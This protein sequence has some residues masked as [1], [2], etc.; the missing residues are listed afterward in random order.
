MEL[1]GLDG[2]ASSAYV[3]VAGVAPVVIIMLLE[4]HI[5]AWRASNAVLVITHHPAPG[6]LDKMV[7]W[8]LDVHLFII[9]S[10]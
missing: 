9:N 6:S 2:D 5:L 1:I 4:V 3:V 8:A 7:P 10:E